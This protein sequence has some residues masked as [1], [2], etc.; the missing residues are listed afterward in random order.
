MCCYSGK[1]RTCEELYLTMAKRNYMYGSIVLNRRN[2]SR[3]WDI[4][5][6]D[7]LQAPAEVVHAHP[8]FRQDSRSACCCAIFGEYQTS[9]SPRLHL[10]LHATIIH[11]HL[12]NISKDVRER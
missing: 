4:Y 1:P 6:C 7:R 2:H 3:W 9:Y 8:I 11:K 5:V 12:R 10:N